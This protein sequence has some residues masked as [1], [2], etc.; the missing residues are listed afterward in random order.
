[1]G[2]YQIRV[3]PN[4]IIYKKSEIWT[5]THRREPHMKMEAEIGVM[6]PQDMEHQGLL[7]AARN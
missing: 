2:L 4:S 6:L 1:M 3:G 5:W 7:A